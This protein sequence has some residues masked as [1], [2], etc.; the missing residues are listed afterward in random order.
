MS[1][2]YT[3][4]ST[5]TQRMWTQLEYVV[6]MYH[7]AWQLQVG[8]LFLDECVHICRMIHVLIISTVCTVLVMFTLLLRN[9]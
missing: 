2:N 3:M 5:M 1:R 7:G 9:R 8:Q 4:K 6:K